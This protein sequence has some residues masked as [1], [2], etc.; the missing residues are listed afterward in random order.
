MKKRSDN[1]QPFMPPPEFGHSLTGMS[2]NVLVTDMDRAVLFARE[3]LQAEFRYADPDI[4]IAVKNGVQW[5][6][7]ADHTYD[8]HPLLP[9]TQGASRRGAGLEIR[10]HNGDPD[11]TAKDANTAGFIVLDGP[12]DQPDHGL[13]EVH[14]EDQDGYVW[15]VDQPL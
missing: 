3:V 5:M 9:I 4:A 6:I 11:Q 1:Q 13:R 14:I 2:L 15:V 10:F 12:R 8:K 7:H